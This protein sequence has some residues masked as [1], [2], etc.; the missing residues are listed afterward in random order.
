[1]FQLAYEPL[2]RI[3]KDGGYEPG[4]A[5]SWQYS[6]DNTVFTMKIRSGVKFAD[7]TDVTRDSVLNTLNYYKSVPGLN[8]GYIKPWKIAAVDTDSIAI[9]SPAPFAG[10]ESVLSDSGNCNN[11]MIISAAG[12]ATPTS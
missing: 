12:L 4:I 6:S 10:M 2:I 1:M 9:T 7:G 5:A 3:T 8:D 11:G